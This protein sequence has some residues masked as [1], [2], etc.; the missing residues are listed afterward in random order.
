MDPDQDGA[1][2]EQGKRGNKKPGQQVRARARIFFQ[3]EVAP[4]PHTQ[5]AQERP[6][7]RDGGDEQRAMEVS[8]E[9]V[10]RKA[11]E[12]RMRGERVAEPKERRRQ[13]CPEDD[14]AG[15]VEQQSGWI[16]QGAR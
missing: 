7:Q 15:E 6:E 2:A 16:F 12:C 8:F 11:G 3:P 14:D 4:S 5:G 9:I 10:L 13:D 1:T